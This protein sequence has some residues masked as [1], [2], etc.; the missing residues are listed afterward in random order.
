MLDLKF[1]NS[2]S[3]LLL[4][5]LAVGCKVSVPNS[6][7]IISPPTTVTTT[8]GGGNGN[9]NPTTST[10]NVSTSTV[11][12]TSVP[13]PVFN[14][15][16]TSVSFSGVNA[17]G[18]ECKIDAESFTT[19]TSPK[20]YSN[21]S[22]GNHTISVRSLDSKK[23]FSTSIQTNF[24]IDLIG[25]TTPVI[26]PSNI[27][28]IL[29]IKN[30]NFSFASNDVNSKISNYSC[31]V[32]NSSY[33]TCMNPLSLNSL[34]EGQHTLK[35]KAID[36][37]G[38]SSL[39]SSYGFTVDT[40]SP[41]LTVSPIATTNLKSNSLS[42][43][44]S[45]TDSGSGIASYQCALDANNYNSCTSPVNFSGLVDGAHSIKIK[46]TDKAGNESNIISS[47][48]TV[49]TLAP[50]LAFTATP[51]ASSTS[52]TANFTFN[53]NDSGSGIDTVQC[54]LD[55]ATFSNC[56]SPLNF[57]NLSIAN[58]VLQIQATD[59]AGNKSSISYAF[60][61]TSPPPV[62]SNP[63]S[64]STPGTI[65]GVNY[66]LGSADNATVQK[67]ANILKARNFLTIRLGL[68]FDNDPNILREQIKIFKA[69]GINPEVI[70]FSSYQYSNKC[71]F[72]LATA[73]TDAY[74]Q[75][76]KM[77]NSLKDLITDYELMNETSLRPELKAEVETNTAT[78]VSA[79]YNK[80]CYE[81]RARI[82]KGMSKA[83]VDIRKSSGLP[84]KII[85]GTVGRDFYFLDFMLER[86]VEFDLLGYHIYPQYEQK[87]LNTDP[88][89][90]T[91]GL[92][93]QLA[94]YKRKVHLN[95]YHCAE[96]Y[97]AA[98]DNKA[99]SLL[100]EN[101]YKSMKKHLDEIF[102]QTSVVIENLMFYELIDE[103]SQ[104]AP[105][106]HFG[107][108]YDLDHPKNNLYVATAY[109]GGQL[110]DTEKLELRNRGLFTYPDLVVDSI[111]LNI[112]QPKIGDKISFSGVVKNTGDKE[113]PAGSIISVTFLV[114]SKS[115]TFGIAT[116]TQALPV[117]ASITIAGTALNAK[118]ESTW[119]VDTA[120]T[121]EIKAI[122]DD[123]NRINEAVESNNI[124]SK[125]ITVLAK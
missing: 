67:L 10:S 17:I 33:S 39:E 22:S 89:F 53:S 107:L 32:D 46:V 56:I 9:S 66:H 12:F 86:G 25:P 81:L 114:N 52:T 16:N 87:P 75:S 117:G 45:G 104:P 60:T 4:L 70:I 61:V 112:A 21:L 118:N 110:S 96:I 85:L 103:P 97:N 113:A 122:V 23:V 93:T 49:D 58:H 68:N 92:F 28:S 30:L 59:K 37:A 31:S 82:L 91:G 69:Q 42:L 50:S 100:A 35:V 47:P 40:I 15:T 20:N 71:T 26:T 116:L 105:E 54:A 102:T 98:F 124:N 108:M 119:N 13:I 1:I 99:G 41:I 79:Y 78:S 2:K 90:G 121:F 51:A 55:T 44:F 101:C 84:L 83:I 63:P 72:D 109:S 77:V 11:S 5:I 111:N 19:C 43:S 34:T 38:N 62:I 88:W 123:V 18:Y 76:F 14:T 106:N 73:E 27:A 7:T 3:L 48:F 36:L 95:E 125:M 57:A 80:T 6:D 29:N 74:N 24:Q 115:V 64:G 120:G 8:S 94:K 65:F